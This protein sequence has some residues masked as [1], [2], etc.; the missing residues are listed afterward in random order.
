MSTAKLAARGRDIRSAAEASPLRRPPFN[1]AAVDQAR[2]LAE[3]GD[4]LHRKADDEQ[5][6]RRRAALRA[7]ACGYELQ[8]DD[9][10]PMEYR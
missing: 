1:I 2:A 5:D 9:L 8:A 7:T 6:P 4:A 10:V 3:C